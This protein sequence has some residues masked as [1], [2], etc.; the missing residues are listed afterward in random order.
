[1][2]DL[3]VLHEKR[4]TPTQMVVSDH[5]VCLY[6]LRFYLLGT[7]CECVCTCSIQS[8]PLIKLIGPVFVMLVP[9][10]TGGNFVGRENLNSRFLSCWKTITIEDI[11]PIYDHCLVVLHIK[12]LAIPKDDL[13]KCVM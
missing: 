10:K 5:R 11:K 7:E 2:T 3:I 13:I 1:M 6:L 8:R 4:G 9:E 12:Y